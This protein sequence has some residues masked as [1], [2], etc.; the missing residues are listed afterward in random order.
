MR[1][2]IQ[3]LA[4]VLMM[5][6]LSLNINVKAA[7]PDEIGDGDPVYEYNLY[8]YSSINSSTYFETIPISKSD[9]CTIDIWNITDP[10]TNKT[11]ISWAVYENPELSGVPTIITN[12]D[13]YSTSSKDYYLVVCGV[14]E[15]ANILVYFYYSITDSES[16]AFTDFV[17]GEVGIYN[18]IPSIWGYN[19]PNHNGMM[20]T[21]WDIFDK[22][23]F[24]S[25]E[26][27]TSITYEIP[28][29]EEIDT[30]ITSFAFVASSWTC[31][32]T[33]EEA[34]TQKPKTCTTCGETKGDIVIPDGTWTTD[35]YWQQPNV[36]IENELVLDD[37][38]IYLHTFVVNV[39]PTHP[40][41]GLIRG[42]VGPS[43]I[44]I[45]FYYL[46]SSE[47]LYYYYNE[48][49]ISFTDNPTIEVSGYTAT[50]GGLISS[51]EEIPTQDDTNSFYITKVQ[52]KIV[53]H[54]SDNTTQE[55]LYEDWTRFDCFTLSNQY[56]VLGTYTDE[57]YTYNILDNG[58][59]SDFATYKQDITWTTD[60]KH[61]YV[62]VKRIL[63]IK[64]FY[65][66]VIIKQDNTFTFYT[67]LWN[68]ET[69][70]TSSFCSYE[71]LYMYCKDKDLS[72]AKLKDVHEL[73]DI[74]MKSIQKLEDSFYVEV[75]I[76]KEHDPFYHGESV[77]YK[78]SLGF[79]NPREIETMLEE[80]ILTCIHT[81]T[82][83]YKDISYV[84]NG[85]KHGTY[86]YSIVFENGLIQKIKIIVTDKIYSDYIYG[87]HLYFPI[88]EKLSNEEI[89]KDLKTIGLL[90]NTNLSTQF[91]GT[92]EA[93][94][95]YLSGKTSEVG[96]YSYT[97]DYESTTGESGTTQVYL[98]VLQAKSYTTE[99][100][101][102]STS[103]KEWVIPIV[104]IIAIIFVLYLIF[105]KRRRR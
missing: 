80:N 103:W 28:S 1:K 71:H 101:T 23:N 95:N 20:I 69:I 38:A 76:K 100:E 54:F 16:F 91:V 64:Y 36:F 29:T 60:T 102:P 31:V 92:N 43:S 63:G 12:E 18:D 62:K 19:D 70:D 26:Q 58:L 48:E 73:E 21:G 11:V 53:Y 42:N 55:V 87:N 2:I 93:S 24:Q 4:I 41:E 46:L 98:K 105:G 50:Y 9:I 49:W 7:P 13:T 67:D 22:S 84:G 75:E 44:I 5:S 79:L 39:F 52:R 10:V 35:T 97:V 8:L 17:T 32:H 37:G 33:W 81:L 68:M 56:V 27:I 51:K 85:T 86:E 94:S 34:T 3:F 72:I 45:S 77:M 14:E 6:V 88:N 47:K 25:N 66:D 65:Q 99:D 78:N 96:L 90:P 15:P 82:H 40:V 30:S 57:A 89:V 74:Y 83:E 59:S 104:V 61:Y